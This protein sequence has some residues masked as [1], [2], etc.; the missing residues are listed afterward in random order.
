MTSL[1][2]HFEEYIDLRMTSRGQLSI[3]GI[4][5]TYMHVPKADIV[6]KL[7]FNIF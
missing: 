5:L 7:N 1:L 6:V 3:T 2:Y 4:A